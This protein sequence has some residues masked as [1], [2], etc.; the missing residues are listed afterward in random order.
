MA[1]GST[2]FDLSLMHRWRNIAMRAYCAHLF[3]TDWREAQFASE[4]RLQGE[5]APVADILS[6]PGTPLQAQGAMRVY[7]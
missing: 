2:V 4:S 7:F 6:V 1:Q 3:D 5:P